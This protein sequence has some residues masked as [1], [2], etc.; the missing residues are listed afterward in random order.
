MNAGRVNQAGTLEKV[1]PESDMT[2]LKKARKGD[3]MEGVKW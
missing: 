3:S 1:P 2:S